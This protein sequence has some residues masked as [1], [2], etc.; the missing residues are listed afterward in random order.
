MQRMTHRV[1]GAQELSQKLFAPL[2]AESG[3]KLLKST[4]Y[5]R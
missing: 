2:E 1:R 5:L 4:T 3:Q